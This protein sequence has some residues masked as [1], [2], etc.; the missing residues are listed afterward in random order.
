MKVTNPHTM[1]ETFAQAFN[2]RSLDNVLALYEPGALLRVGPG[3]RTLTGS[4][5]A[6]E[7]AT[8][9]QAPGKMVLKTNFCIARGD[10]AL[11][12]ADWTIVTD[13]GSI[14]ASGSSA[15]VVRQQPD[16]SWRYIIDHAVGAS[17]P[18]AL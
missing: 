17:L 18:R 13:D 10:L 6:N 4:S 16:G 8:L 5:L 14:I 9:L 7:L 15:E 3:D 1:N 11:L 2:S 12:R